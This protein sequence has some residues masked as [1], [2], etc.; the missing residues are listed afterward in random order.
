MVRSSLHGEVELN[1]D[2]RELCV[3]YDEG[4]EAWFDFALAMNSQCT[5]T[6]ADTCWTGVAESLGLDTEKIS[7]CFDEN[8]LTYAREQLELGQA[9]GVTGSPTVFFE[10]QKYNGARSS[11]G[12]LGALCAGFEGDRPAACDSVIE[13]TV[14]A[15][16]NANC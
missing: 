13:E 3:F 8:K 9:L 11:N 5:G 4:E 10:A 1:Q 16:S 14:A 7:S 15:P 12:Y 6:N 2:I